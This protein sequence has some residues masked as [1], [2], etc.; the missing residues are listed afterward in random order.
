[1]N[2]V[3]YETFF[4]ELYNTYSDDI[5]RFCFLR[6]RDREKALD[7]TQDTFYKLWNEIRKKPDAV[8]TVENIR[9]FLFTVAR[10]TIIDSTRKKTSIPFSWLTASHDNNHEPSSTIEPV[11]LQHSAKNPEQSAMVSEIL[12]HLSVLDEHHK[13]ILAL[14]FL[15]DLSVIEIAEVYQISENTA[16]VRIHRAL[17]HAR[18]KLSHLYE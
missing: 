3:S 15:N 1:M 18:K 8:T 7:A 4:I 11:S 12:E 16:S 17:D 9:G 6:L 10:N 14:R 5:F 2:S 13:E